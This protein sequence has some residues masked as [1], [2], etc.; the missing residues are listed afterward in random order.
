MATK[1]KLRQE[2]EEPMDVYPIRMPAALAR[3][4][5]KKGGGNISEGVRQVG[6]AD[7]AGFVE[8]RRGPRDRRKK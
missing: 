3:H 6:E 7:V 8:R 4:Y 1:S 5:R 2:Q